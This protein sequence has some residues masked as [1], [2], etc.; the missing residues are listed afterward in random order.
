MRKTSLGIPY[1]PVSQRSIIAVLEVANSCTEGVLQSYLILI[2]PGHRGQLLQSCLFVPSPQGFGS[3][4]PLGFIID[5]SLS[6]IHNGERAVGVSTK[7]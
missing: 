6:G 5:R 7:A 3:K 1:L 2:S 4:Q